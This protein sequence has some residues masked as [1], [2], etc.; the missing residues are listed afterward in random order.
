MVDDRPHQRVSEPQTIT[1]ER[2]DA[3]LLRQLQ[4]GHPEGVLSERLG[5]V[6]QVAI[7]LGGGHTERGQRRP[8]QPSKHQADNAL[9]R[10]P[11]R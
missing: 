1:V 9:S 5:D 4:I 10:H 7:G 3:V 6:H 2:D 8:G 11:D